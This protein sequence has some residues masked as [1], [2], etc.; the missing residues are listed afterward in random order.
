MYANPGATANDDVNGDISGLIVVGG[1]TVDTSAPGS[2][3]VT[4]NVSDAAG[5]PAAQVTRTVNVSAVSD[6]PVD[7]L[8]AGGVWSYYFEA[9]A[10][11]TGWT[12]AG[13]DA[14]AWATGL[15]PLGWGHSNLGTTL[16]FQGTRP[17]TSYYRSTFNVQDASG[18]E[19]MTVT[20]RADDGIVVYV[21]GV[22]VGRTNLP[23]G[24]IGHNT[25]ATSAPNASAA[26][27]NPV[28]YTVPGA[29]LQTG[30]NVITA[31][32]H[33]NYRSTPTA[34]F[35]LTGRLNLGTEPL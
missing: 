10:P 8:T 24:T 23:A 27:A 11:G 6:Q 29:L 1:D 33:S 34:S 7:V 2:F 28:T 21:N 9:A 26:L 4:Y 35:E 25:Y 16:T 32:V 18:V 15:A 17:L 13:F 3:T 12:A 19:S 14:S 20:T 5:N 30:Q 22:E 31:E